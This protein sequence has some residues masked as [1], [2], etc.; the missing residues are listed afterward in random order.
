MSAGKYQIIETIM[1]YTSQYSFAE[2][3]KFSVQELYNILAIFNQEEVPEG[4]Q[5]GYNQD[6]HHRKNHNQPK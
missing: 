2:L 6:S 4:C 1:S 5:P 3:N